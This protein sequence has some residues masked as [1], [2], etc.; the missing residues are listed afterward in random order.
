MH[1]SAVLLQAPL[2]LHYGCDAWLLDKASTAMVPATS[3]LFADPD[4]LRQR[5]PFQECGAAAAKYFKT[6]GVRECDTQTQLH[7]WHGMPSSAH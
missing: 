7:D 3:C 5:P 2:P 6:S 4:G 1:N